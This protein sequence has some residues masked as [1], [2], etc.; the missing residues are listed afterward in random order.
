MCTAITFRPSASYF[1]RNLDLAYSYKETITVLP[2]FFPLVFRKMPPQTAH[3]AMIGMAFVLDQFPLFYDAVNEHGL[4]MAGLNFPG[5]AVWQKEVPG[6]DNIT[7]FELIPWLLGQCRDLQDARAML[8]RIN[9][10]DLP[11]SPDLPLSPLHFIL[12]DKKSSLILECMADGIHIYED[13]LGVLTN[14]PPYPFHV[15]NLALYSTL[16]A[17]EGENR[18][19]PAHAVPRYCAGMGAFGLPGDA[20]SPSR[21]VRAAFL[22]DNAIKGESEEENVAQFFHLLHGVE[23][24]KGAVRLGQ[25]Q[26]DITV[27]SSCMNQDKGIYYYTTYEDKT[28]RAID[29]HKT[30]PDASTLTTYPLIRTPLVKMN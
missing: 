8:D 17:E 10:L 28:I 1:G 21:F 14:N 23:M 26:N 2:R 20:S 25:G 7:P 29:L 22:R 9:L 5:N 11:F 30:S 19:F 18:A 15:Q 13:G 12:A 16:T 4:A 6:K 24:V 3:F 27:Y